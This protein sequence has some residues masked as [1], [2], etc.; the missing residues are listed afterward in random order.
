M[1]WQ[2]LYFS[3]HPDLG[4]EYLGIW[5]QKRYFK[6]WLGPRIKGL[7]CFGEKEH[8]AKPMMVRPQSGCL[9][10]CIWQGPHISCV[11]PSS[12][13]GLHLIPCSLV[14]L[15]TSKP[16]P[17]AFQPLPGRLLPLLSL[18]T[19]C[20]GSVVSCPGNYSLC[21]WMGQFC[22]P[23]LSHTPAT[24]PLQPPTQGQFYIKGIQFMPF[25]PKETEGAWGHE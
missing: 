25:P 11:Q 3:V 13:S 19:S 18:P 5:A 23:L 20:F 8:I 2:L 15:P 17:M 14:Q 16:L 10:T 4:A 12:H 9:V 22:H 24:S 1:Y 7:H 6:K 21:S